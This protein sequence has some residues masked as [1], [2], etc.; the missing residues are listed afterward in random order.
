MIATADKKSRRRRSNRV[1]VQRATPTILD[2]SGRPFASRSVGKVSVF[3]DGSRAGYDAAATSRFNETHFLD[4]DGSDAATLV[5]QSLETLRNRARYEVRNNGYAKGMVKTYA[6]D[7]VGSGPRLQILA[8]GQGKISDEE[9]ANAVED[10]FSRWSESCGMNGESLGEILRLA[11]K[12]FHDSGECFI[13]FRDG[14]PKAEID[15]VTLRVQIVEGDRVATPADRIAQTLST[16]SAG[17][18]VRDGIEF[19]SEG[20]PV[21]YFVSKK[22]P[23]DGLGGWLSATDYDRVEARYVI[24]LFDVDR[25]GQTRGVP[26]LTPSL[27]LFSQLRRYTLATLT[28]AEIAADL[29]GVIETENPNVDV[30]EVEAFDPVEIER[31]H[32][33]TL[34]MNAKAKQLKAEQPTSQ[35]APF[36]Q[37]ILKEIGRPDGMPYNV[38]A[39]DSSDYNYASGRMDKQTYYKGIF[40]RQQW[41]GLKACDRILGEWLREKRLL[42]GSANLIRHTWFWDGYEHVDPTKEAKA[43]DVRLDNGM[44]TLSRE[45]ARQGLDWQREREQKY[46]E[47]AFDRQME[48]KYGPLPARKAPPSPV[49][50]A[51]DGDEEGDAEDGETKKEKD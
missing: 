48:E 20:R 8:A 18:K 24:H 41:L 23:G 10:S 32:F 25:P 40:V 49:A 12:Q 19:D 39:G 13:I 9:T 47:A 46:I 37:E 5:R 11:I 45:Y 43:Q 3:S 28:A 38:V 2:S 15:G 36:K 26:W 33:M 17:A 51:D 50:V 4:A 16:G 30:A 21:A 27:T 31:G 14:G 7:V 22:H 42:T 44:T 1:S 34:P 29:A 6:D 35:Y